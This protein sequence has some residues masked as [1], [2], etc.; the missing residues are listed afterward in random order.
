MK[1]HA[2]LEAFGTDTT[3]ADLRVVPRSTTW[4]VS[5]AALFGLAGYAIMLLSILPPH[6]VW[7]MAGLVTGTTLTLVKFR[8]RYTLDE[9]H[10]VCPHC[11]APISAPTPSRLKRHTA[12]TCDTCHRP[13]RLVVDFAALDAARRAGE[14]EVTHRREAP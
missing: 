2:S 13:S 4:R 10:A 11:G 1:I 6:V 9:M 8:E 5:R 12:L 14:K 7:A 3:R